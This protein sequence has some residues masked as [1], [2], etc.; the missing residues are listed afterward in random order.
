MKYFFV[1]LCILFGIPEAQADDNLKFRVYL[2]DKPT[3][4]Y[5]LEKPQAFL[6]QKALARRKKQNIDVNITDIP[7]FRPYIKQIE[8]VSGGNCV[9]TSRW[10]N[11]AVISVTDSS[12]LKK[13]TALTFVDSVTLVWVKPEFVP[14]KTKGSDKIQKEKQKKE[15]KNIYGAGLQQ[16][17]LHNGEKLHKA[18]FKGKGMTIAVIDAG[19]KHAD[20][21]Y[22][23]DQSRIIGTRDFVNPQ[24]DF[25]N[26]HEH[27]TMV[28]ATIAAN[29]KGILTGTAP[30]ASFWLLRSED[31]DTEFPVEED[32][33]T[34]A[35]E[36]ADSVG[37]D[38]ITSSLGYSQYDIRSLG[39]PQSALGR[40]K[41]FITRTAEA[42][43][44]KGILILCSAGNEYA[45][46]WHSI[47]I[48]GD[49]KNILTVGAID[50]QLQSSTFSGLGYVDE[51]GVKPDIA[52]LGT[53]A[54]T[55]D[56]SGNVTQANGTSFATPIMA[57]LATCLWQALPQLSAQEIIRII[58]DNSSLR[59]SPDSL[60]GYGIPDIYNAYLTT[61]QYSETKK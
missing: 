7:V 35:A 50:N 44:Q 14:A 41:S 4:N 30:E 51:R 54:S 40:N 11:T 38:V 37:V 31:A 45:S 55:T 56:P 29:N 33:W 3:G 61:K 17:A 26:T 57:G 6:S 13:I 9:T 8:Q 23:I 27:G 53:S 60:Q 25:Y 19:F 59:L 47:T 32:Y 24:S 21:N 48:P 42:G 10:Q 12:S 36:F 28:L 39:K 58:R 49:A 43:A 34:A 46:E 20:K 2:K 52:A 22:T 15:K 1:L 18:G 16:I 5:N